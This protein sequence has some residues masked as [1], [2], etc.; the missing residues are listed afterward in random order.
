MSTDDAAREADQEKR[1]LELE[2][3]KGIKQRPTPGPGDTGSHLG[4]D[5]VI[6]LFATKAGGSTFH[7]DMSLDDPRKDPKFD[8]DSM[9]SKAP[10][11]KKV[12]AGVTYYNTPGSPVNYASGGPSGRTLRIGSYASGGK[13][14]K[15]THNWDQHP[16]Y[17]FSDKDIL[18]SEVS[19]YVRAHG[20][21]KVHKS[22][23]FKIHGA[24]PDATRS[25]FETVFPISS[26]DKVRANWNYAHFP[27]V[28]VSGIKQY[29]NAYWTEGK[30]VGLK[31]V[32]VVPQDR[33]S[34]HNQ[35]YVDLD[36]FDGSGKIHNDFKLMAEWTDLGCKEYKSIPNTWGAMVN[37]VRLDGY[38][39]FDFCLFSDREIQVPAS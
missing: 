3:I 10:V 4:P 35:L 19:V 8:F 25:L 34:S 33:K 1:I 29:F 16:Q 9:N 6:E 12:E 38:E 32:H 36:P 23:A 18:N 7:L 27:Y 14:K 26:S 24:P 30:W 5:G 2:Y 22:C 13:D 20:D 28:G 31:H 17:L 11:S 15:Q 39:N 21:L 37:K